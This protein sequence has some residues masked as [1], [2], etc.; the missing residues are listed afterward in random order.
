MGSKPIDTSTRVDE[1]KQV[2]PP[3]AQPGPP[4]PEGSE[5]VDGSTKIPQPG[6]FERLTG[7]V[8]EGFTPGNLGTLGLLGRVTNRDVLPYGLLAQALFKTLKK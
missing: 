3:A 4:A 2:A 6:F 8:G 5:I 1:G 7:N